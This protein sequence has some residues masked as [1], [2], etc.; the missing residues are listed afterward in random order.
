MS[1]PFSRAAF[2]GL[3]FPFLLP[4]PLRAEAAPEL[5]REITN[6]IDNIAKKALQAWQVPGVALAV[7][8]RGQVYCKGYGVKRLGSRD[9]VTKRTVFPLASCTKGFTTTALAMLVDEHKMDWDDPVRKHVKFFHLSDPLADANVTLRDI[10]SHR[11]G[12]AS[13]DLLWYRSGLSQEELI[14]RIGRVKLSKPFRSAYQYQSIMVMAAGYAVGTASGKPWH[15][16]VQLRILKPLGMDHTYWTTT[17]ALTDRDHA[18][19][20]RKNRKHPGRVDIVPWYPQPGPDPAGSI[21]SCAL[22]LSRWLLFQLNDGVHD[23]KRLVSAENLHVPRTPQTIMILDASAQ[24]MQP[25]TVQMSYGMGWVIQDYHGRLLNSHGGAI[26][27]FRAH[28]TLVP[29]DQLGIVLLNNLEGSQMN[30]AISNS[31]VDLILGLPTRNWNSYLGDIVKKDEAA[32]KEFVKRWRQSRRPGT[33]PSREL[34]A[35]AGCYEDPA[36]GTARVELKEGKLHWRWSS[37]SGVLDHFHYD[38]FT[39]RHDFLGDPPVVFTLD[40]AGEVAAMKFLN[41]DFKR[42]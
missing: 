37:F 9:A 23:G 36:Y 20:H 18:T 17:A 1:L 29:H 11:T 33:K 12:V 21:S 2:W 19:G 26:D 41:V 25:E 35:Y 27:G 31:I 32:A 5:T 4:A 30:L 28:F 14:R 3:V 8:Y 7:V 6:V 13:H 16:F 39:A 34:A 10:A 22:D 38:T 40:A 15:E 42:R 24:A